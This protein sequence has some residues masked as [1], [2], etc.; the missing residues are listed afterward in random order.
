MLINLDHT[1]VKVN[2]CITYPPLNHLPSVCDHVLIC[3]VLFSAGWIGTRMA[4]MRISAE[5]G[6]NASLM[7]YYLL[8]KL[9]ICVLYLFG[10]FVL[11]F[12][13][14]RRAIRSLKPVRVGSSL[15]LENGQ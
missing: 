2:Y 6:S 3:A 9:Q 12:E 7:F 13:Y 4:L 14:G 10:L 5:G 15:T 1:V 8:S 11:V